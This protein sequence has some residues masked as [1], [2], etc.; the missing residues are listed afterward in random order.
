MWSIKENS[1]FLQETVVL[2]MESQ[3]LIE[4]IFLKYMGKGHTHNLG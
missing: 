1:G 4:A 3:K 2:L